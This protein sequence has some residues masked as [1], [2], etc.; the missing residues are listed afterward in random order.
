MPRNSRIDAPGALHHIIARGIEKRSIFG[1]DDDRDD[2][3]K[4]LGT[5]LSETATACYAWTLTPNHFHLLLRTGKAPISTVMRR[6]L[7][8]YAIGYNYRHRRSGHLFQNRFKSILC[9]EDLYFKELLRY[10]H[11][12]PLRAKIVPDLKSL[13]RYP[14]SGHSALMGNRT[15]DWQ[16]T[17]YVLGLFGNSI[18]SGRRSYGVFIKKGVDEGNR[19]DL[20]GGGLVRSAGGWTALKSLRQSGF[21]QKAD[22]RILGDGDFVSEVL[23]D[24]QER[25]ERKYRLRS[26]GYDFDK[27]VGKVGHLL[28]LEPQ[29]VV[30]SGKRR[31]EVEARNIVCYWASRELGISQVSLAHKFGLSQPAISA[32]IQRGEKIVTERRLQLE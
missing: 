23:Q 8:G 2:F 3:L 16:S 28:K 12:N 13:N 22:E 30:T 14:Y 6:V 29:Q 21:R 20:V 10:I 18:R 1:D 11:L 5:V 4:R 27:I 9:Q 26:A 31:Y 15:R 25:L 7:T 19:P 24:A 17:E 32:A